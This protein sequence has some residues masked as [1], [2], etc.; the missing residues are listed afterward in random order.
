M[1]VCVKSFGALEN[2]QLLRHV[3]LSVHTAGLM[4]ISDMNV[5]LLL[6]REI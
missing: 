5:C 4:A 6:C 3:K 1:A 2:L